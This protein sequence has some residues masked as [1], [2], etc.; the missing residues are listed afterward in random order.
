METASQ[1]WVFQ[2]VPLPNTPHTGL[3]NPKVNCV[4]ARAKR[5][6]A[7]ELIG[8]LRFGHGFGAE[9]RKPAAVPY[10]ASSRFQQLSSLRSGPRCGRQDPR[11]S[12]ALTA[13]QAAA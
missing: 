6:R 9:G 12:S 8:V 11:R 1:V 7:I 2:E 3:S 13:L 4:H 5:R 10:R